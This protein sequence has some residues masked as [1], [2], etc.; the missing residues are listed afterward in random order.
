MRHE[1]LS[2]YRWLVKIPTMVLRNIHRLLTND[3]SSAEYSSKAQ[4][5]EHVA[6]ALLDLDDPEILLDL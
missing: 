3:S 4:V 1:F 2:K 5:D 6:Q